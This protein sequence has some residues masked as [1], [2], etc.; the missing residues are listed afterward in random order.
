[1]TSSTCKRFFLGGFGC[2]CVL[3][4][5]G[6]P[7]PE[8]G[9]Y[10]GRIGTKRQVSLSVAADGQA[11]LRGYW[12]ETLHGS[13]ERGSLRGEDME[14]L[15]FEGPESKK[16]KLRILYQEADGCMIIRGIQSRAFGPGARYLP[17]EKESVFDPPPRLFQLPASSD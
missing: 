10:E 12:Q 8:E 9:I 17:T 7:G 11:E 6:C 4:L 13:Y 16:F 2:L 1:M 5:A 15:V 3:V 14:A